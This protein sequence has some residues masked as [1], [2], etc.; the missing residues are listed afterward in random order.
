MRIILVKTF[1]VAQQI[2][3]R[4]SGQIYQAFYHNQQKVTDLQGFYHDRK[5]DL[6][7]ILNEKYGIMEGNIYG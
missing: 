5:G 3:F 1:L 7:E 6:S 2:V 4:I